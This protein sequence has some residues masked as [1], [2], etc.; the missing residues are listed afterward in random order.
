M[1][2]T[3]IARDW[4]FGPS[5]VRITSTDSLADCA[6]EDY[7][8]TQE[9]NIIFV[10]NGPFL[11][12]IGDLVA[13][14][15][16][17]GSNLFRFNGDDFTTLVVLPSSGGGGVILPVTDGNL[18]V[19]IGETGE[20]GDPG[21]NASNPTFHVFSTINPTNSINPN[22]IPIY[23]DNRGTLSQPAIGDISTLIGNLGLPS[24]LIVSGTADG[25]IVDP[26]LIM[27]SHEAGKGILTIGP[28]DNAANTSL[29]ITNSTEILQNTT[30]YLPDPGTS[31]TNFIV[32]DSEG[33]QII[34]TGPV[35]FLEGHVVIGDADAASTGLGLII[36]P[37]STTSGYFLL[38][39]QN[40]S[41]NSPSYLAT[42][43]TLGQFTTYTLADP[44]AA[45]C[46]INVTAA[47]ATPGDLLVAGSTD[48][49]LVDSGIQ[50]SSIQLS[51]AIVAE[52]TGNVANGTTSV[53]ASI[54]SRGITSGSP[55]MASVVFSTNTGI[56]VISSTS[57]TDA[58]NVELSAIPGDDCILNVMVFVANQ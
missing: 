28:T 23:S 54:P 2:I 49:L 15:A 29:K 50:A 5:I 30:Y 43:P 13:V 31:V 34:K 48:G 22:Y 26:E 58:I 7:L 12:V 38:R 18:A 19:F 46:T 14:A 10:N 3:S 17:D 47:G 44:A 32:S 9:S 57:T 1:S 40:N 55:S 11:F 16:S 42:N 20:I 56:Y 45:N 21:F 33:P 37:P 36:Y 4:G 41:T 27:Y 35:V 8:V 24:G 39:C 53:T 52:I 25:S 6:D 51:S